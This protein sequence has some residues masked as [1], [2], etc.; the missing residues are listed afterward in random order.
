ML[1][2]FRAMRDGFVS[3]FMGVP[4]PYVAGDRFCLYSMV[5]GV[6]SAVNSSK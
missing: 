5:Y 1:E 6:L 2:V 4:P 3:L